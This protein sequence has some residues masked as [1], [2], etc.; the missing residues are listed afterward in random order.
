[1]FAQILIVM[2]VAIVISALAERRN[3]QPAL[4]VAIVGLAASFIPGMPRL[5]LEPETVV[6][7]TSSKFEKAANPLRLYD[8]LP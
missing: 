2:I 1:M 4:L 8:P 5:E 3:V 7:R 6:M